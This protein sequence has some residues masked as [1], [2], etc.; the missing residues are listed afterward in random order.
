MKEQRKKFAFL[1]LRQFFHTLFHPREVVIRQGTDVRYIYFSPLIQVFIFVFFLILC[2]SGAGAFLYGQFQA[3]KF[4]HYEND[5]IETKQLVLALKQEIADVIDNKGDLQNIDHASDELLRTLN[6]YNSDVMF[7]PEKQTSLLNT[8]ADILDQINLLHK[9]SKNLENDLHLTQ[10]EKQELAA[11]IRKWQQDLAIHLPN[12]EIKNHSDMQDIVEKIGTKMA[13]QTSFI[14]ESRDML[15]RSVKTMGK[16]GIKD[17]EGEVV[18]KFENEKLVKE[19]ASL[20]DDVEDIH[21]HQASLLS[22]LHQWVEDSY[23]KKMQILSDLDLDLDDLDLPIMQEG[24]VGGPYNP[25]KNI[26][27]DVDSLD[28]NKQ[29]GIVENILMLDK[30]LYDLRKMDEAFKCIPFLPPLDHYNLTSGFGKRKDPFTGKWAMHY[31][32]DMGGW[33]GTPIYAPAPGEVTKAGKNGL[34][35][36]FVE[37]KHDCGI[38]TRYGHLKKI[39]VKKGDMLNLRTKFALLG[40]SGRSTGAHL[41][42]EIEVNGKKVNPSKFLTAGKY[43]FK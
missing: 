34:Y 20:V 2:L 1:T 36:N 12:L 15:V 30:K 3:D 4:S 21:T 14:K 23:N 11:N 10:Q 38:I 29:K 24:G 37:I 25:L 35:G 18:D 8:R 7:D 28:P 43:V 16:V 19:L 22:G 42:Y 39:L 33:K 32:I 5:I 41:H 9:S 26:D 6:L 13:E 40:N 31:G 17:F 27:L